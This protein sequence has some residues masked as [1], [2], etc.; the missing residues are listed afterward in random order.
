[1]LIPAAIAIA[2]TGTFTCASSCLI[3]ALR[4]DRS[5]PGSRGG[6]IGVAPG[7]N[8][9]L[10]EVMPFVQLKTGGTA[11]CRVDGPGDDA[12]DAGTG[13]SSPCLTGSVTADAAQRG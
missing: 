10:L 5:M 11:V 3:P 13:A 2:M 1:M 6:D 12:Q 4:S 9:R 7:P 8:H